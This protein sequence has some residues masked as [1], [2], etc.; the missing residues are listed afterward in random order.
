M[1]QRRPIDTRRSWEVGIRRK[2]F[3]TLRERPEFHAL[4]ALARQV[5]LLR[6]TQGSILGGEGKTSPFAKRQSLNS[7]F[8]TCSVLFE[9]YRLVPEL[10]RHF[11]GAPEFVELQEW[12]S[13]KLVGRYIEQHCEPVRNKATF[14]VDWDFIGERLRALDPPFVVFMSSR[15][16]VAGLNAYDLADF[17][18]V[19]TLV[20][21]C[22]DAKEFRER[23][24]RIAATGARIAKRFLRGGEALIAARIEEGPF[25]ARQARDTSESESVIRWLSESNA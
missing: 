12:R 9:C 18:A 3:A 4:V 23:S 1:K 15:G 19:Q 10:A 2:D 25:E 17:V 24:R 22:K 21:P 16:K 20:G 14:H 7:M 13:D 8:L 6:Y 5:N 11:R